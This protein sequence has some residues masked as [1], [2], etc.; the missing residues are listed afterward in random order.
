MTTLKSSTEAVYDFYLDN[1]TGVSAANMVMG[2]NTTYTPSSQTAY[3]RIAV[4]P[5]TETQI[6]MGTAK[7]YREEGLIVF[8]VYAPANKGDSAAKVLVQESDNDLR[9][10]TIGGD[11][12]IRGEFGFTDFGVEGDFY[13]LQR[14]YSYTRDVLYS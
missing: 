4:L 7:D 2:R 10:Q 1:F 13:H 3:V 8:D 9:N 11:L 5:V 14:T 12:K 6:S